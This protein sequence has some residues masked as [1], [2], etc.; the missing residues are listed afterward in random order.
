MSA[1]DLFLQDGWSALML[2]SNYGRRESTRLL[3]EYVP[4]VKAESKVT[5]CGR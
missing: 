3:L 4:D 2:A 5:C 1:V